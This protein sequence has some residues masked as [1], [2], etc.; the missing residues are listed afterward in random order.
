MKINLREK[1]GIFMKIKEERFQKLVTKRLARTLKEIDLI[2]NLSTNRYA[3]TEEE[4]NQVLVALN[5]KV[6]YVEGL[7]KRRLAL[8]AKRNTL[9]GIE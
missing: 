2:S 3:F 9:N 6:K 7:F 5:N 4:A 1:E 8:K